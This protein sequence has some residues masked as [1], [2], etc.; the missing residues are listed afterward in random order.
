MTPQSPTGALVVGD[1]AAPVDHLTAWLA[2]QPGRCAHG[3]AANQGCP[4]CTPVAPVIGAGE[5][6]LFVSVVRRVARVDGTVHQ[7]DVRPLIR[8]RIAPKH[9][10][11]LYRRARSEG[12][13]VDTGELEPSN[14]T[15]GRNS[16]KVSRIYKLG[17]A[18]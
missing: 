9:I 4:D 5:W 12:L 11:S 13:L 10:G 16:D 2:C 15:A 8:G 17:A 6:P 18:A 7:G 14:D 3:F 1:T